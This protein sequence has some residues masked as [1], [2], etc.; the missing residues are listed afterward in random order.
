MLR[1]NKALIYILIS[2]VFLLALSWLFLGIYHDREFGDKYLF[3]KHRPSLKFRFFAPLGESDHTLND[4]NS[5][6][7]YEEIMYEE[8]VENGGGYKR[9][10]PLP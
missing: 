3:I 10:I 9:S 4:L 6:Q 1:S 2:G 5:E 7:R 8:Y